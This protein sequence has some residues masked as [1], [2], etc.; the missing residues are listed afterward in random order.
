MK[1]I[2]IQLLTKLNNDVW[3]CKHR[4]N[5]VTVY[6]TAGLDLSAGQVGRA[7]CID[8]GLK[9]TVLE[10]DAIESDSLPVQRFEPV[11]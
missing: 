10:F 5:V 6:G 2:R 3:L 9:G 11:V 4:D 7:L 1:F 8:R